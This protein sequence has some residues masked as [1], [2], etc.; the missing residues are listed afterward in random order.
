[1]DPFILGLGVTLVALCI[2]TFC[3][4]VV[5]QDTYN[6]MMLQFWT[7]MC[8]VPILNATLALALVMFIIIVFEIIE[9]GGFSRIRFNTKTRCFVRRD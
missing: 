1:M 5:F 6:V 3:I 8:F 4:F 7:V 2:G 9:L